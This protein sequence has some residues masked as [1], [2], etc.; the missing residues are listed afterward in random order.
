[1]GASIYIN[2]KRR[3]MGLGGYPDV[4]LA[5]ARELVAKYRKQA[6]SGI[7]PILARQAEAKKIPSFTCCAAHYI[8]AHRR[9]WKNAKHARQWVPTL[10]PRAGLPLGHCAQGQPDA[11]AG[12]WNQSWRG[13]GFYLP[14]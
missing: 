2:G 8:R 12:L 4:S 14:A 5:E 13:C 10:I 6:K 3:E 1:M 7:D 9:G 11:V